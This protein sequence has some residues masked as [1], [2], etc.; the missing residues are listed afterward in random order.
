MRLICLLIYS[1]NVKRRVFDIYISSVQHLSFTYFYN[2]TDPKEKF[3]FFSRIIKS[4]C[5]S[6]LNYYFRDLIFKLKN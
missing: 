3:R 2:Y 5:I 6:V 4:S 1:Y